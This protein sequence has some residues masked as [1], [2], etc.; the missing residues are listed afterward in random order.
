MN[1]D[2]E[3][4]CAVDVLLEETSPDDRISDL[5]SQLASQQGQIAECNQS[6]HELKTAFSALWR[7]Y[8]ALA[9][10]VKRIE[11]KGGWSR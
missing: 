1:A 4:L 5:E 7:A 8:Q 11:R 3:M 2:P 9:S 6:I 10:D